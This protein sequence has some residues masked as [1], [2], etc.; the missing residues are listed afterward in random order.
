MTR[1]VVLLLTV[2][3]LVVPGLPAE[4]QGSPAANAAAATAVELSR[5]EAAGDFNALYD[6]IHPDAHAVIP[7]AAAVGWFEQE[8]APRGPGVSTVTDVEFGPWTWEVTGETY[9]YTATVSFE[10]PFADGS[11]VEDVVR[12]VQ[13]Q[14][15]EWRWFFGRTRAFVEAQIAAYVPPLPQFA[16]AGASVQT[17]TQD[18]DTFWRI[19]FGAAGRVYPTPG[20]V[21]LD[22]P[23]D[24]ACGPASPSDLPAAY[25]RLDHTIYYATWFF[26][27]QETRFGDYAWVNILAH[28][29]GHHIQNTLGPVP[30]ASNAFE[31]QADCLAGAYA[32]DAG[33]RGLLD[34]GDVTEAV[35]TSAAFG[36][37]PMWP[38]DRPGAHGTNDD[39][40]AAFM[41]GYLDG[42]IGC[43]LPIAAS[44]APSEPSGSFPRP[45]QPTQRDLADLAL[46]L[47]TL[48][49]LPAGLVIEENLRR[50]LPEVA[51]NYSDPAET[52]ERFRVWGW[53]ENVARSYGVADGTTVSPG[54]TVAI[55]VSLHRFG[56]APAAAE[57]LDYSIADQAATTGASETTV[58]R[59]LGE[60]ARVLQLGNE[61]TIY[62]QHGPLLVRVTAE[63][64]KGG[65]PTISTE[66]IADGILRET[67]A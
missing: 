65:D 49:E 56:T 58:S 26:T 66:V 63:S 33:T 22:A 43:R 67:Q 46:L 3:S 52:E 4:A 27:E 55:Y 34:P 19:A 38:Q 23:R 30:E 11:V 62:A 5:L 15:G 8:F 50:T 42:F 10:Q 20:I 40:I 45:S 60:Y 64:A 25:C 35:M 13:D 51:A 59:P 29:W 24:T 47:P 32:R 2:V 54:M 7:R 9:P 12:L 44:T 16:G 61:V 39:R 28:E 18:L 1:I 14:N 21:R 53:T 37:D 36:D 31:L 6:R 48:D 17:A 41:R 57:A